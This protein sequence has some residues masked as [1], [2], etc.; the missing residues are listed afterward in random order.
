MLQVAIGL[1]LAVFSYGKGHVQADLLSEPVVV[2][3][4]RD[5]LLGIRMRMEP[6]WHVYWRNPGD[7]G[8]SL[9]LKWERTDGV[10]LDS[11][12]WPVPDTIAV[13][14]LMTYGYQDSVVL[15]LPAHVESGATGVHL[16]AHA[17]WLECHEVCV[18]GQADIGLDLPVGAPVGID[19][20][21][22]SFAAARAALPGIPP[23]WTV[24]A[25]FSDSDLIL[26]GRGPGSAPTS[27]RF[28]PSRQGFA[29]NAPA[30]VLDRTPDGFRLRVR[31]DPFQRLVPDSVRGVLSR[32]DGW[33]GS[34]KGW[35]IAVAPATLLP[36][37]T[38]RI[39]ATAM[40]SA[41]DRFL[42][43][44]VL[45]FLGGLL[46]NLMPC[47][48]PVLSLKALS[49]VAGRDNRHFLHGL[50]YTGGVLLS[51]LVLAGILVAL[52]R[53]GEALGWGFQMQSPRTVAILSLLMALMALSL[54]GVFEPGASFA[55]LGS[56][57]ARGFLGSFLT[58]VLATV[59]ATPCTAPFMGSAIGWALLLPDA[60]VFA[61]FAALGLGLAAP[62]L[63]ISGVPAARRFLPRPG[64]WMVVL[65]QAFGFAMAATAVW[66]AWIVGRLAGSDAIALVATLWV[67]V[68]LGAWILGRGAL[69]HHSSIGRNLARLAFLVLV[70]GSVAAAARWLPAEVVRNPAASA[71]EAFHEGTLGNLRSSGK[72]WLL[73]FTA[74][75]CLSCQVNERVALR[76][77]AVERA[78]AEKGVR[79]VV[80]DWTARDSSVSRALE[81]FGRQGVP[82]YVLSDG[83]TERTLPEILTESTV[84]SALDSL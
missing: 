33:G 13:T 60:R 43:A 37:D 8:F 1:A 72:P 9:S 74:D 77:S 29:D 69:P 12:L 57:S 52:R 65:K 61:V 45:A 27:L 75:W 56:S 3:P 76:T 28:F 70:G 4:G 83:R 47:V 21:S 71:A 63:A 49:L 46:L 59:V 26:S 24:R 41:S 50:A 23:G 80:A 2:Q 53:G 5:L 51:F 84:L 14:P 55:G 16:R 42:P 36:S 39:A 31:R 81:S 73:V 15:L 64:E 54:W 40:A 44:L 18:P 48:L 7:A 32:P 35:E 30:Q 19:S 10:R 79:V 17:R 11:L 58:G 38:A 6:G 34:L 25:S 82:F 67:V 62:Y 22:G 20:T 66:L 78:L 68:A